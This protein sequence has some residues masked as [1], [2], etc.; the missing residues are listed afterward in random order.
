VSALSDEQF[1]QLRAELNNQRLLGMDYYSGGHLTHGYRFNV[2]ARMFDAAATPSTARPACST[3]TRC[4]RRCR[5]CA[6]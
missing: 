1:G 5:S 6:R 4:A 2:S 3:S